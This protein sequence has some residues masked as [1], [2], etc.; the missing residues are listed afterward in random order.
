[1]SSFFKKVPALSHYPDVNYNLKNFY[2][3]KLGKKKRLQKKILF[4][5]L[6]KIIGIRK[7]VPGNT[8]PALACLDFRPVGRRLSVAVQRDTKVLHKA[9]A[10]KPD[11]ANIQMVV[12]VLVSK[13]FDSLLPILALSL[14]EIKSNNR[15]FSCEKFL[16]KFLN[17]GIF[18]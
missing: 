18:S 6:K 12:R 2:V 4:C 3:I 15:K 5:G 10:E 1:M 8:N 11:R 14:E 17:F 16:C 13:R 9:M 7:T